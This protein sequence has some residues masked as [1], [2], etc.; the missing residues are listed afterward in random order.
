M[1][2][3]GI[4]TLTHTVSLGTFVSFAIEHFEVEI[5]VN[6]CADFTIV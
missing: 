2:N 4:N 5:A 3:T 1:T 6:R